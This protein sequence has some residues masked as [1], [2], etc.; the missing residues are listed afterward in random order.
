MAA[1][2]GNTNSSKNNRLW[3]NT[4][5]RAIIQ[6]DGEKLR[7]IADK[8]IALAEDGDLQAIKELGDRLDGKAAQSV[9]LSND[10]DE[11][12]KVEKIV[13]QIVRPND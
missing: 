8:L 2:E 9:A 6:G 13:R 7:K 11:P 4:I 3:A 5:R 10:G 12:F 1:P